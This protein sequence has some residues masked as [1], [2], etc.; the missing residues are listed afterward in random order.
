MQ[1]A[2]VAVP[3]DCGDDHAQQCG[4]GERSP[5]PKVAT[6]ERHDAQ[7]RHEVSDTTVRGEQENQLCGGKYRE[8]RPFVVA[9]EREGDENGGS[10]VDRESDDPAPK[11]SHRARA[12]G[13]QPKP[14]PR[15]LGGLR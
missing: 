13:R 2:L 4:A 10:P 3:D 12:R 9:E 5:E 8:R 15:P 6:G 14:L 7:A 1:T 11:P